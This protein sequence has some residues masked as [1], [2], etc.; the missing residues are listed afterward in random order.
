MVEL[1]VAD[2]GPG[3]APMISSVVIWR[4]RKLRNT[5]RDPR[6]VLS[7]VGSMCPGPAA[8]T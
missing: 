3:I 8:N 4:G 5:E 1:Q 6:V 7:R 2:S